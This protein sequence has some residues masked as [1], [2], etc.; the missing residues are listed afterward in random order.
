MKNLMETNEMLQELLTEMKIKNHIEHKDMM[1]TMKY[2][3]LIELC[4]R[5]LKL[6]KENE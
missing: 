1:I 4:I 3:N 6:E 5:L 2:S